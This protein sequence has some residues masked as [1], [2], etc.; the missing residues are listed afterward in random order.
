M[1]IR[2]YVTLGLIVVVGSLVANYVQDN[3]LAKK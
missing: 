1:K 2:E 3:W